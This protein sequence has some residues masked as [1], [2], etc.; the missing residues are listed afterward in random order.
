MKIKKAMSAVIVFT[1]FLSFPLTTEAWF[2]TDHTIF[3][4]KGEQC[5]SL[6]KPPVGN[7]LK[8]IKDSRVVPT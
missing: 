7:S 3:A 6:P 4:S 1:L 5:V 2:A 8:G